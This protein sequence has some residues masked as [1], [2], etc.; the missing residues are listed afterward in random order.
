MIG[1]KLL[2][3]GILGERGRGDEGKGKGGGDAE[4]PPTI[5]ERPELVPSGCVEKSS[6]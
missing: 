5:P 6:H 3:A 2:R 4:H 1:E